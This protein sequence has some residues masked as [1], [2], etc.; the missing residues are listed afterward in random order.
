MKE[1][2]Q[3]KVLQAGVNPF[4]IKASNCVFCN[5]VRGTTT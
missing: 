4:E 1:Q 3:I 5:P 2:N